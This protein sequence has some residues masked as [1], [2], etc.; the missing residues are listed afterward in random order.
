MPKKKVSEEKKPEPEPEPEPE[1]KLPKK[2]PSVRQ[3]P[4][5]EP[6]EDDSPFGKMKLKKTETVKRTWEDPGMQN[7][8]LKH[9]EFEK[10]PQ[11]IEP[12]G[13]SSVTLGESLDKDIEIK[14]RKRSKK[15][16]SATGKDE[17]VIEEEKLSENEKESSEPEQVDEEVIVGLENEKY[18][19]ISDL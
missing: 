6:K 7:V 9:H 2:K 14:E 17:D 11:D 10:V 3:I 1:F 19:P 15:K 18:H 16:K 8:E 12:E 4:K 13:K 5:D